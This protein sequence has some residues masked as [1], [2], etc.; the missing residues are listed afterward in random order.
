MNFLDWIFRSRRKPVE[1]NTFADLDLETALA[2]SEEH[3]KNVA[4]VSP[5][6]RNYEVMEAVYYQAVAVAKKLGIDSCHP[7][8]LPALNQ[9]YVMAQEERNPHTR[10]W[11]FGEATYYLNKSIKQIL[12]SPEESRKVIESLDNPPAHSS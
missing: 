11:L 7:S 10:A 9:F 2:K 8:D 12:D 1:V 5:K 4:R 6:Y 3:Y